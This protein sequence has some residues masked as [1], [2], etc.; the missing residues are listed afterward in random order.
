MRILVQPPTPLLSVLPILGKI[1]QFGR[2][3]NHTVSLR[4]TVTADLS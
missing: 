2:D 4:T 3:Q 1:K